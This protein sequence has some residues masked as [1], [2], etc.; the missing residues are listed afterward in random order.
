MKNKEVKNNEV[1]KEKKINKTKLHQ[2]A[3]FIKLLLF[4]TMLILTYFV[5]NK[6]VD[7]IL[8][9]DVNTLKRAVNII[10]A[11]IVV[12]LYEFRR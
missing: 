8:T 10:L 3:G 11:V 5:S 12:F 9:L 7:Y 4:V 2:I 6:A 1:K